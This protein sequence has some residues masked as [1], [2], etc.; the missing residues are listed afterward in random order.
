MKT[1]NTLVELK[2]LLLF[3]M[4]KF[5]F[6]VKFDKWLFHQKNVL[7]NYLI[8]HF[9]FLEEFRQGK[10][11]GWWPFGVVS[12]S[13][14]TGETIDFNFWTHIFNRLLLKRVPK[15]ILNQST[16]ME[17]IQFVCQM[18][19]IQFIYQKKKKV[20]PLLP[21]PYVAANQWKKNIENYN[22]I[23]VEVLEVEKLVIFPKLDPCFPNIWTAWKDNTYLKNFIFNRSRNY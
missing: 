14:K 18:E 23:G 4:K 10:V 11:S 21:A 13:L 2:Y 8:L 22:S 15:R 16:Q 5:R 20:D 3:N 12:S 9:S 17:I 19:I 6:L 1:G 7:K